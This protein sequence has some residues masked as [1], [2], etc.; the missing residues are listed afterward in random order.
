MECTTETIVPIS[1]IYP[2]KQRRKISEPSSSLKKEFC[3]G[4]T[5]EEKSSTD[6]DA[7]QEFLCTC[8]TQKCNPTGFAFWL[9]SKASL[10]TLKASIWLKKD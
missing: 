9:I 3:S 1:T 4:S 2:F 5:N 7:A 8:T 10:S 6:S